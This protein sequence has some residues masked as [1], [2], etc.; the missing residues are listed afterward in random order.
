MYEKLFTPGKIGSLKIKNRIVMTAM[1]NHLANEDGTVSKEDI[2]F[3]A[4][5]AKGEVGLIITECACVDFATGKGNL[6]QLAIDDDRYIKGLQELAEAIHQNGAL[7]AVQLY[8]PGRQ[9]IAAINGNTTMKAPSV[10]EC[11]CVHQPTHEMSLEEIHEMIDHFV[12]GARRLKEAG[13]DAVELHGAHGYLIGQF[14]SPYTNKRTDD[15]GGSFKNRMRFLGEIIRGIKK[16]C[17]DY[18]LLVRFSADEFMEYAGK[19]E[20]GLHLLDGVQIAKHLEEMGVHALNVSVGIYETMN[21]AWEPVGFDQGW[22]LYV[23]ATIKEAVKIPVIGAALIREPHIAEQALAENK[24]DFIGSARLFLADAK[25]ALKVKE[26]RERDLRKCI[27]CL[28]CMES[29]MVADTSDVSMGCAINAKACHETKFSDE[30]LVQDGGQRVVVIIG[31]GPAGM[32]AARILAKREFKPIVFEKSDKVGGQIVFGSRPPKKEK[33]HWL[34]D[35]QLSQ[36]QELGVEIRLNHAPTIEDI[37]ELQPYAIFVAQGANSIRPESIEGIDG[38]NVFTAIDVLDGKIKIMN[39]KVAVIGSGLTGLETAELLGAQKNQVS[40]FEMADEIGP[41][42]FF[43]NLIDI[44]GRVSSYDITMYPK[45]KLVKLEGTQV[46]VETTD[47]VEEKV[48]EFDYVVISLGIS[49]NTELIEELEETFNK[50]I[51]LGDAN[52][53]GRIEGA[54]R[55]GYV[56]AYHL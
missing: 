44:L 34:I 7:I 28:Y 48:F 38:E 8:H 9:G 35:Y 5:R 43:Q 49:S 41:D 47:T 16:E 51:V 33:L 20:E 15:Y 42:I 22:K 25:W 54:V 23:P 36:L 1:G 13:I 39:Q 11:Q 56:E 37:K 24:V 17:G 19:P 27:S 26:G 4:E 55:N 52:K 21:T 31:A 46:V 45:H 3:Y 50:V 6:R 30:E 12:Q 29:L 18:P 53:V 14:L 2:A 10:S 32:E 40:I